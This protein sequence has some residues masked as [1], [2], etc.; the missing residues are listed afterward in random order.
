MKH[1]QFISSLDEA[2]ITAAIE[3][4]EAKST[5]QIRVFISR[6]KCPDPLPVAKKHFD[7]LGMAKTQNRNAILL[8]IAPASH[9]FA[10]YGDSG[11]HAHCGDAFW[12]TLRDE[13]TEH[14]KA[15]R[16]TDALIHTISKA[17]ELLAVHFPGVPNHPDEQP[18]DVVRD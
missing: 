4:A 5:G 8:F 13:M 18:N 1:A 11:I 6:R 3:A 7:A 15:A 2:R 9:T 12:T 10:I 14:L 16:Y 17:G